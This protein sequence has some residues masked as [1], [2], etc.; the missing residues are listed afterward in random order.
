MKYT[1]VHTNQIRTLPKSKHIKFISFYLF[2]TQST[3]ADLLASWLCGVFECFALVCVMCVWN[4]RDWIFE[5]EV[6]FEPTPTTTLS[7]LFFF[8]FFF[9]SFIRRR[10]Q[11][12]SLSMINSFSQSY[13]WTLRVWAYFFFL[14]LASRYS[15]GTRTLTQVEIYFLVFT[16]IIIAIY[17][18]RF[19]IRFVII[20]FPREIVS[21]FFIVIVEIYEQIVKS[22][23]VLTVLKWV[24]YLWRKLMEIGL[25]NI[26]KV[27]SVVQES[28]QT[29][30][31]LKFVVILRVLLIYVKWKLCILIVP[32]Q[33]N[34]A[35]TSS[36]SFYL[37]NNIRSTVINSQLCSS[38]SINW[39][40]NL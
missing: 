38:I 11:R 20:S 26:E 27:S 34:R 4:H 17:Y 9:F 10:Q 2:F 31:L 24:K 1:Y 37:L 19:V 7:F 32:L 16:W 21:F 29:K 30:N 23:K 25:K 36:S 12:D 40:V 28:R 13:Q 22:R 5:F 14:S 33:S 8:L 3:F 39:S 35:W 18:F 15:Y 6:I